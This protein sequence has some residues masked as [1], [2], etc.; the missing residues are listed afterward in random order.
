MLL[1][2]FENK[3]YSIVSD[4]KKKC[5]GNW[6]LINNMTEVITKLGDNEHGE[7]YYQR[8]I[9]SFMGPNSKVLNKYDILSM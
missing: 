5:R 1:N 3:Q 2:F 9:S 4:L 6:I 7:W 8:F